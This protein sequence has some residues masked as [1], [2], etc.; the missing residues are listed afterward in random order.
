LHFL[1]EEISELITP[2]ATLLLFIRNWF[3]PLTGSEIRVANCSNFFSTQ[4]IQ[5]FNTNQQLFRLGFD[6]AEVC[7]MRRSED[8]LKMG[9]LSSNLEEVEFPMVFAICT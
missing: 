8:G 1:S 5:Y 7:N 6:G 2:L 4:E 3:F 9:F